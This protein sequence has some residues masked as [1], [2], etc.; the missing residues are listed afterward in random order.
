MQMGEVSR[1]H[2]APPLEEEHKQLTPAEKG[3]LAS[4]QGETPT[5]SALETPGRQHCRDS[6]VRIYMLICYY[7]F[8]LPWIWE[9]TEVEGTGERRRRGEIELYF[10]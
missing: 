6:A 8:I 1:S 10:N 4:Q 7:M 5:W 9:G 3:G 2:G